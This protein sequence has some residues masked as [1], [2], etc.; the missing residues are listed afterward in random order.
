MTVKWKSM[1][2]NDNQWKSNEKQRKRM[3]HECKI[4]EHLWKS[5][6]NPYKSMRINANRWKSIQHQCKLM[7]KQWQINANQWKAN[8]IKYKS[9]PWESMKINAN[10]CRAIQIHANPWKSKQTYVKSTL[11]RCLHLLT[12]ITHG[13]IACI[14]RVVA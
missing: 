10:Q 7:Q 12:C 4:Y 6:R 2:I 3:Q 13:P 14:P 11:P 1:N 9:M 5:M 8:E